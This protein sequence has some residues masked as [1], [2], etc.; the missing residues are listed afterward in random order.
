MLHA[1][2]LPLSISRQ[3]PGLWV[4]AVP[5]GAQ[6]MA[7]QHRG[8]LAQHNHIQAY[9][10]QK[11]LPCA[12]FGAGAVTRALSHSPV[13]KESLCKPGGHFGRNQCLADFLWLCLKR[14]A[15]Q[16]DIYNNLLCSPKEKNPPV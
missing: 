15:A 11:Y 8:V 5:S 13:L 16:G 6:A 10:E 7:E 3:F 2:P 4:I 1:Y 14:Q 9:Y 12:P